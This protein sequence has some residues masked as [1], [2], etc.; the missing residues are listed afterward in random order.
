MPPLRALL[1]PAAA[2]RGILSLLPRAVITTTPRRLQ[3]S[4][5]SSSP[6]A[7]TP[8][9]D[10]Q[11]GELQGATFRIEPLRR[12]GE[13]HETMRARLLCPS[14]PPPLLPPLTNTP[15]TNPASAEPSNRT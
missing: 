3:S 2:T 11:V 12:T 6:A 10:L 1:R 9:Q 8:Q 14:C 15:Q 13:S 7:E 4:S 5:T